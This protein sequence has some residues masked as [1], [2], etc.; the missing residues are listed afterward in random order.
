MKKSNLKKNYIYN[1]IYQILVIIIP[2]IVTPYVSRVLMPEGIGQYSFSY[3]LITYFTI[4]ANMG[5]NI[6]AQREIAAC[7]DDKQKQSIIFWEI[8]LSRLLF[9][10]ISLAVNLIL[11]VSGVYDKYSLLMLLL[12]I[13]ILAI[14]FDISFYYQGNEEFGK[15][16][17]VNI[18]IKLLGT[19][20]IFV[21]VKDFN[22][23]WIYTLLNSLVLIGS[24]LVMWI[25]LKNRLLKVKIKDLKPQRHFKGS[26]KLFIPTIAT[27]LYTVLDKSLIGIITGSDAQNGYYESAEKI[28]RFAMTIITCWGTVMI[29][30]NVHEIS[31]GNYEQVNK[32]SYK[33]IHFVWLLGLPMMF[34]FIAV[35]SNVIPWFLGDG[36]E[37]SIILMQVFSALVIFI[38]MSNVLGMQYLVPFKRDKEFTIAIT[39]GAITNVV[40]NIPLIF[41][42]D[43]LG[44]TISSVVAEF[45]VTLI[46]L[47]ELRK[48]LSIKEI[49]KSAIKPLIASIIIFAVIYPLSFYFSPSVL[50]T[51]IIVLVGIVIY[52][53]VILILKDK[54]VFDVLGQIKDKFFK[55]SENIKS[56]SSEKKEELKEIPEEKAEVK[57]ENKKQ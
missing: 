20:S 1:V 8:N 52:G 42:L 27:S 3:S 40:L 16:V 30:R 13:N 21:F 24:N 36:Y 26:F 44:A 54:L 56:I 47:I 43:A 57:E 33:V 19:A 48:N 53:I 28:V 18:I 7:G 6:Y 4:F 12:S 49:F 38:G 2:I 41:W 35:A 55:K 22:D 25:F 46:M 23:V 10:G 11:V 29:P 32:N 45:V 51:F 31:N 34:G 5:Y 9:V 37:P 39:S 14:A 50:N 15:M 17:F